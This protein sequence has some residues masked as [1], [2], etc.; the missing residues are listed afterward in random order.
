MQSNFFTIN[1]LYS[2]IRGYYLNKFP[3]KSPE[4][5]N[6]ASR[7]N[8]QKTIIYTNILSEKLK[9]YGIYANVINSNDD[10][11]YHL[12]VLDETFDAA[13]SN[14]ET[15]QIKNKIENLEKE[16]NNLM[17]DIVNMHR[18]LVAE[19]YIETTGDSYG[20][21]NFIMTTKFID[22]KILILS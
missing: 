12:E 11:V 3:D 17:L 8:I 5:E 22:K 4:K 7:N 2:I 21:L 14:E 1:E 9:D 16:L 20:I 18:W 6:K 19:N 10:G 15:A 13:K